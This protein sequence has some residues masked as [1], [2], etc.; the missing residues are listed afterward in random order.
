MYPL[1]FKLI[2]LNW[3]FNSATEALLKCYL[4]AFQMFFLHQ[5]NLVTLGKATG[6]K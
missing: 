4:N 2:H 6:W 1:K 3:R 5:S